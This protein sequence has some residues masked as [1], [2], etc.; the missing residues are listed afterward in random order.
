MENRSELE[1][2]LARQR[3]V[4]ELFG[5]PPEKYREKFVRQL[6]NAWLMMLERPW[7]SAGTGDDKETHWV[8]W[9]TGW[10]WSIAGL[11][12]GALVAP[13]LLQIAGFADI[14]Y[15]DVAVIAVAVLVGFLIQLLGWSCAILLY[16][17]FQFLTF[18]FSLQLGESKYRLAHA[19]LTAYMALELVL[20]LVILAVIF[21]FPLACATL[22]VYVYFSLVGEIE[23]SVVVAAV[24]GLFIKL[25][26]LP[27]IKAVLSATALAFLVRWLRG[28]NSKRK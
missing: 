6:K 11:L 24:G 17:L 26:A 27:L 23:G 12:L 4:H 10:T 2:A 22:G 16:S 8:L 13:T 1:A 15:Y 21:L 9:L 14:T 20:W 7:Q 28:T 25:V 3:E 18:R 19:V 5:R